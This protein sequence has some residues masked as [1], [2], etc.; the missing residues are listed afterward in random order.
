[1]NLHNPDLETVL[2]KHFSYP[3]V[4]Q[5]LT[6]LKRGFSPQGEISI[7]GVFIYAHGVHKKTVQEILVACEDQ[8]KRYWGSED[9]EERGDQKAPGGHGLQNHMSFILIY[10]RLGI[11]NPG[12][13]DISDIVEVM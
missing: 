6:F 3:E 2:G 4:Q 12:A 13:S 10:Q 9:R 8:W 1:M 5:I 11:P 7:T